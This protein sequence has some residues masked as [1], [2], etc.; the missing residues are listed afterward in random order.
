MNLAIGFFHEYR[1]ERAM[2]S[3]RKL[4]SP[5]ATVTRHQSNHQPNPTRVISIP[6]SDV[7]VGDIVKLRAGQVV[8]AD[9]RLF[10]TFNLQIDESLLTGE[11]LAALKGTEILSRDQGVDMPIGDC[12][13][14][15]YSGTIVTKGQGRGIVYAI[16]MNTEMGKIAKTLGGNQATIPS[17]KKSSL[18]TRVVVIAKMIL[19]LYNTSPLQK[20][21]IEFSLQAHGRLAKL[22]H[23]L[24]IA[25][26]F[27]VIIVFAISRFKISDDLAL[28]AI[29]LALAI[30]PESL[31]AVVTI[32]MAKGVTH[33]AR[34]NAIVRSLDAIEALGGI[35]DICSDK[36]GT[37]TTGNMVVR[38][39]WNG[40]GTWDCEG[41][42]LS[43]GEFSM[44]HVQGVE[45]DV[46]D[47]VRCASLCNDAIL[48]KK[49]DKWQAYGEA[50]EVLYYDLWLMIGCLANF[51]S[52]VK[53]S[54]V[55]CCGF[56]GRSR[57][58]QGWGS[59]YPCTGAQF[60]F[61][62]QT[63]DCRLS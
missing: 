23:F 43:F 12:L 18:R 56:L 4:S 22:A 55:L 8:P 54:K 33:M 25:A 14:V 57:V 60:R 50:T 32:T 28:Y 27:L 17:F 46:F 63:N 52:Q 3:L 48:I 15:A 45:G 47:L 35:A 5:M 42:D 38:K 37:L 2:D 53:F 34:R 11:S 10:H 51:C 31:G 61:E 41:A 21:Y 20:R 24:F 49:R 58:A 59:I 39:I 9:I 26:L 44:K 62:C 36:T 40:K 30:I 13:N 1:A 6:T 29:A 19:G 16:G 7:V